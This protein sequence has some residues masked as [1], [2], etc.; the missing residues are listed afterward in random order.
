MAYSETTS[1]TLRLWREGHGYTEISRILGLSR[2]RVGQILRAPKL[3]A[4]AL[5]QAALARGEVVKPEQCMRCAGPGPL[6]GHHADYDK[7]LEVEW[8]CQRCHRRVHLH[9]TSAPAPRRGRSGG[10]DYGISCPK[11]GASCEAVMD[12]RKA[13]GRIRRRRK[14]S[15]CGER[16]TTFEQLA[17]D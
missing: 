1:E 11:C 3:V 16:V 10:A 5:L 13:L 4:R 14:C 17:T 15:D 8:L 7:P 9:A 6:D 12:T 2:Q